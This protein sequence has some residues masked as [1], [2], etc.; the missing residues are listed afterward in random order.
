MK[1]RRGPYGQFAVTAVDETK[2]IYEYALRIIE[3]SRIDGLLP[4]FSIE[5][6]NCLELSFDFSGLRNLNEYTYNNLDYVDE[7]REAVRDFFMLLI[8]LLNQL[9][10]LDN[11]LLDPNFMYYNE[12]MNRIEFCYLPYK[13]QLNLELSSM[14]LKELEILLKHDFFKSCLSTDEI[15]TITYA[16]KNNDEQLLIDIF[17]STPD[18]KYT[19]GN[20]NEPLLKYQLLVVL[21]MLC[22]LLL[23]MKN[24]I[25]YSVILATITLAILITLLVIN[26]RRKRS[27]TESVTKTKRTEILFTQNEKDEL[28]V[29]D[30]FSFASL[31]STTLINGERMK[32]GLYSNETIIGSDRFIADVYISSPNISELQAKIIN[33]D[34]TYWLIDL[35]K[36]NNTYL[37]NRSINNNVRYEIKNGQSIR[38]GEEEFI[39]KIGY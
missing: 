12:E 4:A 37:E 33:E 27:E 26:P 11:I 2:E 22:S 23:Y 9:L 15:T 18:N 36:Q 31:E 28:N 25:F 13:S 38:F 20:I 39:F 3:Y 17:A 14:N 16:V 19:V 35:S 10:P 24:I 1:N 21:F 8:S 6:R 34:N 7:K 32:I 5:Q 29:N 30:L